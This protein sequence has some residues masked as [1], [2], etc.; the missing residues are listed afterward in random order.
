MFDNIMSNPVKYTPGGEHVTIRS[1]LSIQNDN[2]LELRVAIGV[3]DTGPGTNDRGTCI[4]VE[5]P[6]GVGSMTSE[7]V[8][9]HS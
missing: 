5:L 8:V 1:H 4:T 2:G 7:P 9:R 3:T 6:V